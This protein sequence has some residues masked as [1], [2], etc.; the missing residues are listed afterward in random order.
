MSDSGDEVDIVDIAVK[1]PLD[2]LAKHIPDRVFDKYQVELRRAPSLIPEE[3]SRIWNLFEKNM[4]Q[5][6]MNSSFGWDPPV[7]KKE[8]FD[9]TGYFML[10][11]DREACNLVAFGSFR[12]DWEENIDSDLEAVVY[13]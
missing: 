13:W 12:F 7:K 9:A 2:V 4:K 8:M 3:R 11:R 10:I 1:V 5:A 6:Y